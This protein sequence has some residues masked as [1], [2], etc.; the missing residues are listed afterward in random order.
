M[1]TLIPGL[2]SDELLAH[3]AL[4]NAPCGLGP[5]LAGFHTMA[6]LLR[7]SGY[8]SESSI[9]LLTPADVPVSLVA[10]QLAHGLSGTPYW[11][12]GLGRAGATATC[13]LRY[14]IILFSIF[15]SCAC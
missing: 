4:I 11:Q 5:E 1:L 8:R 13:T 12:A 9:H 6:K 10:V 15:V 14:C 3:K 7:A 2:E